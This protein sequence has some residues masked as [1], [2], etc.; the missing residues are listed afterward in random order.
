MSEWTQY[1]PS[2]P[3]PDDAEW[4]VRVF[5]MTRYGGAGENRRTVQCTATGIRLN[6]SF[7][8]SREFA[9][10]EDRVRDVLEC[11][12]VVDL[13]GVDRCVTTDEGDVVWRF[14]G[15]VFALPHESSL[16]QLLFR[17]SMSDFVMK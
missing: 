6:K 15:T 12:A 9:V 10:T 16:V 13:L 14:N 1:T 5:A 3:I 8:V 11:E 7:V 2:T 17:P 4:M